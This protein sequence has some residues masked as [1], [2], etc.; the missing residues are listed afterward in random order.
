V[1]LNDNGSLKGSGVAPDIL[2]RR[3]HKEVGF[4]SLFGTPP[5]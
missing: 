4:A 3:V 5:F 1:A 2:Y